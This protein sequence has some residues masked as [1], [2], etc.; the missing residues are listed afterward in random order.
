MNIGEA[1]V[2]AGH[3]PQ[4][5]AAVEAALELLETEK[6]ELLPQPPDPVRVKRPSK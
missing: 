3:D 6:V 1:Q 2:N 4:L 5:E